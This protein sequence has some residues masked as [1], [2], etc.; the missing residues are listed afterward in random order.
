MGFGGI[1]SSEEYGGSDMGR[2]AASAIFE[3]LSYSCPS[4][5]AYISI[6]NMNC[7]VVDKYGTEW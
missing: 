2:L 6:M 4:I 1:Y 3:A 7:M 5:S